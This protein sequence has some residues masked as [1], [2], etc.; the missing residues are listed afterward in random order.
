MYYVLPLGA[1]I[2]HRLQSQCLMFI[3]VNDSK[4]DEL[5]R[6][7]GP[8]RLKVIRRIQQFVA[9][10]QILTKQMPNF[11]QEFQSNFYLKVKMTPQNTQ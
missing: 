7:N 1:I 8:N 2:A 4:K 3:R 9:L 6:F 11:K 5:E 10:P